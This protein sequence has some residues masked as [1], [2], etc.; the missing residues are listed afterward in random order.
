MLIS[1]LQH[2]RPSLT[3]LHKLLALTLTGLAAEPLS[4]LQQLQYGKRLQQP[5][6]DDPVV[7]NGH[8][9]SGTTYLHQLMGCDPCAATA[10]NSLTV[11]PQLALLLQ[12]LLQPL[13]HRTMTPIRPIDAVPWGAE[14]PQEDEVGLSR[15]TMD[16]HMAGIAFPR[17]YLHHL[18]R[19]VL[20][21]TPAYE[22]ALVKFSRLTWL[23]AGPGKHHLLIKNPAHTARVPLLLRLFPRCRFILLK[24]RP[25]DA[26]RSL[27]LVKQRLAS[28]V[29][30]QDPPDQ[31]TQVEETVEAHGLLMQAFEASRY[32]IPAGQLTEV[33]F[34][35]LQDAPVAT[36]ERIYS[37]LAIDSWAQAQAPIARRAAQASRYRP[38]SVTLEPAAEQRLITLLGHQ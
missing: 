24:R 25:V 2:G 27:V 9:R 35:D 6:P 7:V 34:E 3:Q 37:D 30:L 23:H 16:S 5:I 8:W 1:G 26:V 31:I 18:R 32:L 17:D 28:L 33:D 4:W 13:L 19:T 36:V 12:P 10:R 22:R 29:G 21:V 20:Q 14:D 15:L 38:L 11:A